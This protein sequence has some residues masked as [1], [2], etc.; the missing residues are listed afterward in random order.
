MIRGGAF[1]TEYVTCNPSRRTHLPWLQAL[2]LVA[3][4]GACLLGCRGPD[5]QRPAPK[6]PLDVSAMAVQVP[7]GVRKDAMREEWR[8][9]GRSFARKLFDRRP[10]PKHMPVRHGSAARA[11]EQLIQRVQ[12]GVRLAPAS[13]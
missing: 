8:A 10:M 2:A 3:S 11:S 9:R 13:S 5:S 6:L 1:R 7:D 4:L 12:Q